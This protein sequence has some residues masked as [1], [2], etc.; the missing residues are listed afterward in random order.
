MSTSKGKD[1]FSRKRTTPSASSRLEGRVSKSSSTTRTAASGSTAMT[2]RERP[3]MLPRVSRMA[4]YTA[5]G[6]R[7]LVSIRSGTTLPGASSLEAQASRVRPPFSETRPTSTRSAEISQAS[8]GLDPDFGKRLISGAYLNLTSKTRSGV[9]LTIAGRALDLQSSVVGRQSS[10][11]HG[12]SA[13]FADDRRL[14]TDDCFYRMFSMNVTL[15]ISF[16]VVMPSLHL[17]ERRFAQEASCLLRAPAR[18]ISDVG[19]LSRIISRMRSLRSSSSWIAV[20]P[21]NPVP[22]HSKQPA[23]S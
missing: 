3:P 4:S 2:S 10:A 18:R 12:T 1:F 22:P 16:S 20:R 14:M 15:L 19:R 17:V 13:W 23:P 9:P 8:F 6:C 5:S 11:N 7:R 21:R